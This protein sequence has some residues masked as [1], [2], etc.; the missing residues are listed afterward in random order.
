M[1]LKSSAGLDHNT[2]STYSN[3]ETTAYISKNILVF[4]DW[5]IFTTKYESKIFDF[6]T[7]SI[8]WFLPL[9]DIFLP[10]V[11]TFGIYIPYLSS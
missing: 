8:K 1:I 4:S 7:A 9:M 10:H 5:H 2:Y 3:F 6:L 11:V